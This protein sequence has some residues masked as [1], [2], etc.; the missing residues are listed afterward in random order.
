MSLMS[1]TLISIVISILEHLIDSNH[2]ISP[3]KAFFIL[4]SVSYDVNSLFTNVPLEETIDIICQYASIVQIPSV[5]LKELLL[6]CTR[7]TNFTFNGKIYRQIDGVAMGSPLGPILA[8]IFMS[9]LEKH[10]KLSAIINKT[11]FYKRYVDDTFE[12]QNKQIARYRAH[13]ISFNLVSCCT[14]KLK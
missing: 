3:N 8:N 1:G 11:L 10:G 4:F 12:K 14:L 5:L 7:N 9:N 13:G 6:L 2:K